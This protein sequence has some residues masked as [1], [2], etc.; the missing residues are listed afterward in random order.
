MKSIGVFCA[1]K[2]R[3]SLRLTVVSF[4]A[5]ELGP[6]D[7]LRIVG[8]GWEEPWIRDF[9]GGPVSFAKGEKT[10]HFGHPHIWQELQERNMR[11]DYITLIGDDDMLMPGAFERLRK[12][13]D[14]R[15]MIW[16]PM[17]GPDLQVS[18]WM[19]FDPP[20]KP[21][22]EHWRASNAFGLRAA[23][24]HDGKPVWQKKAW[25]GEL[26]RDC[27]DRQPSGLVLEPLVMVKAPLA[28]REVWEE[29][30]FPGT[31]SEEYKGWCE[32]FR[33]FFDRGVQDG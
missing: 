8:D 5:Q 17:T 25:D 26:Y 28:S 16:Y 12:E 23:M 11:T 1:S 20:Q 29:V 18:P 2:G 4:L 9:A 27:A 21:N 10:G 22:P 6:L 3:Q 32:G 19:W 31:W 33:D 15:R 30:G 14:G 13:M 24:V 7:H